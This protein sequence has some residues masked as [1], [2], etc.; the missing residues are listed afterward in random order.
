VPPAGNRD[1]LDD[2]LVACRPWLDER[3]R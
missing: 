2:E 3:I 1:P